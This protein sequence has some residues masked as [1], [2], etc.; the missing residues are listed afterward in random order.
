LPATWAG[1]APTPALVGQSTY[2]GTEKMKSKKS[3]RLWLHAP[4][5]KWPDNN[6]IFF[7]ASMLQR[8]NSHSLT[9]EKKEMYL[10][11][12]VPLWMQG[13]GR[14]AMNNHHI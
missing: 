4:S 12:I 5:G 14:G 6:A 2:E 1:N 13:L 9:A 3:T 10:D 8:Q 11:F 7:A